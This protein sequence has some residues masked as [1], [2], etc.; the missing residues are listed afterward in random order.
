ML[1]IGKHIACARQN[2]R[3]ILEMKSYEL[4]T[5]QRE[6]VEPLDPELDKLNRS[7][8]RVSTFSNGLNVRRA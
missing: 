5:T 8:A 4:L 6:G 3:T 2:V 7:I 1:V